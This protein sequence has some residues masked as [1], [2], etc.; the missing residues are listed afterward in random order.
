MQTIKVD[1][2]TTMPSCVAFT[3]RGRKFGWKA[4]N[5]VR[6]RSCPARLPFCWPDQVGAVSHCRQACSHDAETQGCE[7]TRSLPHWTTSWSTTAS[8]C[9]GPPSTSCLY[10]GT[11]ATHPTWNGGRSRSREEA[12]AHR[13]QSSS[14]RTERVAMHKPRSQRRPPCLLFA[15]RHDMQAQ[16]RCRRDG[17]TSLLGSRHASSDAG[18]AHESRCSWV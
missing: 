7:V 15:T 2:F 1:N 17:Q 5:D 18:A 16:V 6:P 12:P 14:V 8:A 11:G 10:R 13:N 4:K 9:S 3:K